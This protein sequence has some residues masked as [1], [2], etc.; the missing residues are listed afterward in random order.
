MGYRIQYNTT[1]SYLYLTARKKKVPKLLI[2]VL[3]ITIFLSVFG[4]KLKHILLP[5][6]P[7]VTGE[8]LSAFAS[9][10][11]DGT[12]FSDALEAFCK[13]ILEHADIS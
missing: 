5:G 12:S 13:N 2:A 3:V 6:D 8:A 10:M 7:D 9:D 11:K 1:Q 4:H